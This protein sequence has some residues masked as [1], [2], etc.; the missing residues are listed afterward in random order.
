MLEKHIEAHLVKRV[1]EIGGVAYKFVSPAQRGVADRIV[2]LP[3]GQVWFV[4]LKSEGGRLSPLQ[5]VFAAEMRRMGQQ[6]VCLWSKE[7]VN[8]WIEMEAR[9]CSP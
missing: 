6:Y 7:Q 9:K 4:E 2:C 3:G 5:Q 8:E 1:R